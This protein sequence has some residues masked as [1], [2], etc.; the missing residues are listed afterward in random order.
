MWASC[1]RSGVKDALQD[2]DSRVGFHVQCLLLGS[3]VRRY[4]ARRGVS[5]YMHA[6]L[7]MPL[8]RWLHCL[9]AVTQTAVKAVPVQVNGISSGAHGELASAGAPGQE[10]R[11]QLGF[12]E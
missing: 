6:C 7:C 5:T 4:A 1:A 12:R 2:L 3:G 9:S 11:C 8:L 10:A